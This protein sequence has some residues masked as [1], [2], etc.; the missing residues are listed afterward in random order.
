MT[1]GT[2]WKS[3]NYRPTNPATKEWASICYQW[4]GFSYK[5]WD[6]RIELRGFIE[7]KEDYIFIP[8]Q[9][10]LRVMISKMS[11]ENIEKM[12][13]TKSLTILLSG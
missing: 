2:T 9:R 4:S 13:V 8:E 1:S 11:E 7:T 6:G 12:Q 10:V 3:F 5:P